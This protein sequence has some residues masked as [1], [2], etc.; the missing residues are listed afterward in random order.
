LG[1]WDSGRVHWVRIRA[2]MVSKKGRTS[3]K[4]FAAS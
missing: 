3:D 1:E 2:G 4:A